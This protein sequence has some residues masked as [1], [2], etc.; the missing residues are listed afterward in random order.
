M[1][2]G[3][4]SPVSV[5]STHAWIGDE[6]GRRGEVSFGLP[7]FARSRTVLLTWCLRFDSCDTTRKGWLLDHMT[8][9]S[10]GQRQSS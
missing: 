4:R 6:Q 2:T 8:G 3:S 7:A 10:S 5:P 1:T 9:K